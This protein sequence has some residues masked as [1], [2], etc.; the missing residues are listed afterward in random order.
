MYFRSSYNSA[1]HDLNLPVHS[2]THMITYIYLSSYGL[3]I[4][5]IIDLGEKAWC[6]LSNNHYRIWTDVRIDTAY[7]S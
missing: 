5:Q 7:P 4:S 2:L 1:N 6:L 3:F